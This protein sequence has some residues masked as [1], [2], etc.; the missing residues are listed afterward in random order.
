MR[1]GE[2]RVQSASSFL[3]QGQQRIV[4]STLFC[5]SEYDP[6]ARSIWHL[7]FHRNAGPFWLN[8]TPATLWPRFVRTGVFVDAMMN[9]GEKPA[10][11]GATENTRTELPGQRQNTEPSRPEPLKSAYELVGISK[12]LLVYQ[13]RRSI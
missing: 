1:A 7:G 6:S 2:Q 3:P 10:P 8:P 11:T 13:A 9:H 12:E 4:A 5:F